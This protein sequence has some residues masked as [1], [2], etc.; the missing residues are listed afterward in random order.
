MSAP[1][2]YPDPEGRP[3]HYRYWDGQRWGISTTR[4]PGAPEPKKPNFPVVAVVVVAGLVIVGLAAWLASGL[5]PGFRETPPPS[6]T[7][8]GVQSDGPRPRPSPS[9]TPS[10]SP[11]PTPSA[12]G[13]WDSCPVLVNAGA[14]PHAGRDPE[15]IASAELS[16]PV[17][18]GWAA[19]RDTVSRLL[20][21]QDTAYRAAPSGGWYS[22]LITGQAPRELGFN[23]PAEA[24]AAV[25]EC[26]I[27]G[28]RFSGFT[29]QSV[30][31][32]EAITVDGRSGWRRRVLAHSERAPGGGAYFETVVLDTGLPSGFSVFW[33]GVVASDADGL[34]G[35]DVAR[36]SLKVG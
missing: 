8:I 2:W 16:F 7:P 32:D 1:G 21:E 19:R 27:T 36:T 13:T 17:P 23:T 22:F 4:S 33:G 9:P 30:E 20:V 34:K 10:P 3:N 11:S 14:A 24:A 6:A 28:A 15:R 12:G 31:V 25:I 29:D 5:L 35:L 26:H 18:D